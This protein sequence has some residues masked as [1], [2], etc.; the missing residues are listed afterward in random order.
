MRVEST[1]LASVDR[2]DCRGHRE[3]RLQL[4]HEAM[5]RYTQRSQSAALLE[6]KRIS[7]GPIR[8]IVRKGS[9][10]VVPCAQVWG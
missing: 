4:V 3:N 8:Q 7:K 2:S 1:E 6:N 5:S 9:Y 10:E